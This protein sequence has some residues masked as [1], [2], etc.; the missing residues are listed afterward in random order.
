MWLR[1]MVSRHEALSARNKG[2]VVGLMHKERVFA[3]QNTLIELGFEQIKSHRECLKDVY[4]EE[5]RI[6]LSEDADMSSEER[7]RLSKWNQG[8]KNSK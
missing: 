8:F 3:Y 1:D 7:N 2:T 5:H 6:E 4:G